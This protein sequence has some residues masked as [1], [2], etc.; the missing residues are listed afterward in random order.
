M[1]FRDGPSFLGTP[2]GESGSRA[3][4]TRIQIEHWQWSADMLAG[5]CPRFCASPAKPK[6]SLVGHTEQYSLSW[7]LN[8]AEAADQ[9]NPEPTDPAA[10]L[11]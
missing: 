7:A 10:D 6:D 8:A 9:H 4:S 2:C 1:S 11:S 5:H 3:D